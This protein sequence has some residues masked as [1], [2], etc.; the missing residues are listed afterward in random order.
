MSQ[1]RREGGREDMEAERGRVLLPK[2]EL[3]V[4]RAV[5]KQ[6]ILFPLLRAQ[7]KYLRRTRGSQNSPTLSL[8]LPRFPRTFF[9]LFFIFPKVI[10]VCLVNPSKAPNDT[11]RRLHIRGTVLPSYRTLP[12]IVTSNAFVSNQRLKFNRQQDD[13]REV[14]KSAFKCTKTSTSY[15]SLNLKFIK[16]DSFFH[17]LERK[18]SFGSNYF[19][20]K[21][22]FKFRYINKMECTL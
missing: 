20:R 6:P 4:N 12:L 8:P 11:H 13:R 2:V 5:A 3:V 21:N 10:K 1:L 15:F 18:K 22:S 19:H 14:W 7:R 9:P 17:Y 16:D